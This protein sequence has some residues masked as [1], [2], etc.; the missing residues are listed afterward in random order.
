MVVAGLRDLVNRFMEG[1]RLVYKVTPRSFT[2]SDRE[3]IE[4]ATLIWDML[5]EELLRLRVPRR[6]A[7][8]LSGFN[9][10]QLRENH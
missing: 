6:M 3:T 2:V 1:E 5:D 4:P 9:A 10:R 7:T 8:D